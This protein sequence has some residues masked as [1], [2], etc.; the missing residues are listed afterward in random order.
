MFLAVI[1][2]LILEDPPGNQI[3]LITQ[4]F[5]SFKSITGNRVSEYALLQVPGYK[6]EL[7]PSA[8]NNNIKLFCCS[9]R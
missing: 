5:V 3:G 1:K 7:L 2:S 4:H 6:L 9:P 8:F